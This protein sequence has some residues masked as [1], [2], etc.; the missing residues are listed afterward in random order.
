MRNLDDCTDVDTKDFQIDTYVNEYSGCYHITLGYGRS[1]GEI[2][3]H[4]T[5]KVLTPRDAQR[6]REGIIEFLRTNKFPKG[7][8]W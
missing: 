6:L 8:N 5:E 3:V 1:Y 4:G 2:E 7:N